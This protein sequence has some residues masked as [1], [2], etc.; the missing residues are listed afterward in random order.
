MVRIIP[1][2]DNDITLSIFDNETGQML[3]KLHNIESVDLTEN[4]TEERNDYEQSRKFLSAD[5]T[6]T[7]DSKTDNSGE[8]KKIFGVDMSNLP[9]AYDVQFVKI[10]QARKHRKKR[11]NKKWLKRYGVKQIHV[12]SK[13]WKLQTHT[14]GTY[15]FVK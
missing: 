15:E 4:T 5:Y 7:F 14:D 12:S 3:G 2:K 8:L 1:I 10:M 6:L 9:D 11:I 13:G